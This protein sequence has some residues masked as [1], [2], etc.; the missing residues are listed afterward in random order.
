[1]RGPRVDADALLGQ[2]GLEG[3]IL[4]IRAP[5]DTMVH[6]YNYERKASGSTTISEWIET[7]IR[8]LIGSHELR[9]IDGDFEA[10]HR[11]K[12]MDTLRA[13]YERS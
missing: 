5:A 2:E 12:K 11:G 4:T 13:S 8:P 7:R 6:P 10:P 1:M 3:V 9:I